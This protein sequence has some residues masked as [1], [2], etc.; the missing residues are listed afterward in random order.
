[1]PAETID[2]PAGTHLCHSRVLVER[3]GGT[4]TCKPQA[5]LLALA[6]N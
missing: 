2:I 5:L 4:V 3:G 6:K 1:M